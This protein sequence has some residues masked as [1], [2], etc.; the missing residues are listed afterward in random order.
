MTALSR[1]A[2]RADKAI[3]DVT[4]TLRENRD[5]LGDVVTQLL[6]PFAG[7]GVA[8]PG[9]SAVVDPMVNL[10]ESLGRDVVRA[11]QGKLDEIA[12][13]TALRTRRDESSAKLYRELVALKGTVRSA[14]GPDGVTILGFARR[15]GRDPV[16]VE[17]Q[18]QRLLANLGNPER[19]LPAPQVAGDPANP[20]KT[21]TLSPSDEKS[22]T[23]ASEFTA[24]IRLTCFQ[25]THARIARV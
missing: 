24:L 9:F 5:V 21:R 17:R 13:D 11:D 8:V 25:K 14:H 16:V 19:P 6:Q 12:V 2:L 18:T 20:L 10:L 1:Q 23:P 7:E 3:R 22:P 4:A 15:L